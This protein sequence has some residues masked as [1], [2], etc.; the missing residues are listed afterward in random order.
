MVEGGGQSL[1]GRAAAAPRL[2]FVLS[3]LE[4]RTENAGVGNPDTAR[5]DHQSY[6]DDQ[7]INCQPCRYLLLLRRFVGHRLRRSA[8]R[9]MDQIGYH[10]G[11]AGHTARRRD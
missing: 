11:E 6:D 1:S 2:T 10:E 9:I 4:W 5:D 8:R 3:I 7:H